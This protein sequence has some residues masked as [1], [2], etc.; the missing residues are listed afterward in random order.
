MK[1]PSQSLFGKLFLYLLLP[2]L[3]VILGSGIFTYTRSTRALSDANEGQYLTLRKALKELAGTSYQMTQLMVDGNLRMAKAILLPKIARGDGVERIDAVNQVSGEKRSIEVPLLLLDGK[4]AFGDTKWV[5]SLTGIVKGA[6]T[7]FQMIPGG[8]VRVAT[9]V[10]KADGKRAIGTYIPETSPVYQA[11]RDGREY[12]GR[13]L[14]AG[15]W[16]VTAYSPVEKDGHVIGAL[17]VGVPQENLDVLRE[18]VV[19]FKVGAHG[20]AQIID[21]SGKQII[22]PDKSL[23]GTIR[24]SSQHAAMVANREGVVESRQ[25]SDLNGRKDAVVVYAYTLIPEMQWIVAACAYKDE[26]EAP[27]IRI[28]NMLF[29]SVMAALVLSMVLGLLV[30]R[31]I[32]GSVN[33]CVEIADKVSKG[34]TRVEILVGS[35][36]ELGKLKAAM[37]RMVESIGRM[38]EDVSRLARSAVDGDLSVNV[39]ASRHEGDFRRI[40]QGV[41]DTLGA[42]VVPI[43][44]AAMALDM[45]AERDLTTRM[46]GDYRGDFNSIKASFNKAASNL[47]E[48]MGQVADTAAHVASASG[49][50]GSESQSLANGASAQASSL[51]AI[52]RSL[53]NMARMTKANASSAT[54]AKAIADEASEN[55]RRGG[56]SMD[57]MG[58]AIQKINASSDETAKI[59]KTIDEI[60]MQTN[61]LA[62][63]AAVEAARAGDAGKGFAVVA[64]E[65]R[66]LA[67][68]SAQ[69]AKNTEQKINESVGNAREGAVIAAEVSESFTAISEGVRRVNDLVTEIAAASK[70]Q[71]QG[72]E[73][74]NRATSQ[75]D[76]ITQQNAANSEEGASEAQE[77]G[78]QATEL[79]ELLSKFRID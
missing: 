18:R 21:T 75:M 68:R 57:R 56:L 66:N 13:A 78:A 51:D 43:N 39:D 1:S 67:Q 33:E 27:V 9:S 28:R 64:E 45:L 58:S 76:K 17:F 3:L 60:A 63:N 61:M 35:Q 50:I 77:L 12:F 79:Q 46:T 26:I 73:E 24:K 40:V 5:D 31:T 37:K 36:D 23:E 71:A 20:F 65:V 47:D 8:M 30:M 48:A 32:V 74:V 44:E 15:E 19:S 4:R 10:R 69:A 62:L 6:T 11:I 59:I 70:E 55:A 2:I 25:Q 72:L 42:V 53:E 34:D 22:H 14:V 52:S 49:Q 41:N 54:Q 29:L 16:Y 38:S 7:V